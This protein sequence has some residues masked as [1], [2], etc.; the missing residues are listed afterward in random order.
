MKLLGAL[1]AMI[2]AAVLLAGCGGSEDDSGAAATPT[3]PEITLATTNTAP[4]F[5]AE[6]CAEQLGDLHT[7]LSDLDSRLSVGLSFQDYSER[8]GDVRVAYDAID[9]TALD[10]AC[11]LGVGIQL[12]KA[13]NSYIRAYTRW[14][15]CIEDLDCST[16]SIDKELQR[17]WARATRQIENA[18]LVLP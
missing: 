6:L 1:A 11:T 9:Y 16:D 3:T 15:N 2:L 12:E 8:V 17:N 13:T 5:D 7:A 10:P 4:E 14:N 18:E